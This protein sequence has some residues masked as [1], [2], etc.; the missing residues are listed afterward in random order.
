ML[1]PGYRR[2]GALVNKRNL[3]FVKKQQLA[4]L[5][6]FVSVL[7]GQTMVDVRTQTK[8]IDFSGANS[9]IPAK[10][11]TALPASCKLG[12][13]FFNT[14]NTPGQNL[15]LCAPANTWTMLAGGGSGGGTGS[16]ITVPALTIV[17]N[18]PQYA[19]T[20]GSAL[21]A[22]LSIVT[23]VGTPGSA[24]NIP[25]ESA[26]RSALSA[27]GGTFSNLAGGTN[28]SATLLIGTGASLAP[29]GSG[30]IIATS[31]PAGGVTG[32]APSATTDT[33]NAGNITSGTL[34]AARLPNPSATTLGGVQSATTVSHQWVNSIS[35][36]GVPTLSQPTAADITGLAPS[37]T[38]D[39]TNASNIASGTLSSSL[40]PLVPV[41]K[42]GT[43]TATPALVAGSNVAISGSWP[44]QTISE[45]VLQA[46]QHVAEG[47]SITTGY[48]AGGVSNVTNLAAAYPTLLATAE[49]ATLA[50]HAVAGQQACDMVF[51]QTIKDSNT[52]DNNSSIFTMMIGTN[53]AHVKGVGAYEPVF[54]GCHKAAIAWNAVGNKVAANSANCTDTGTWLPWNYNTPSLTGEYTITPGS[55]KSCSIFTPTGTLYAWVWE[56]DASTGAYT[57]SI[58]GGAPV[59]ATVATSTP[60]ATQNGGVYG[61]NLI[62]FTGLTANAN[63]TILFTVTTASTNNGFAI[64]AIGTPPA[65]GVYGAPRV[66]VGGVPK[67]QGDAQSAATA[68]YNADALADV[69]LLAG[70]GLNVYFVPVRNYLCTSVTSGV[71]YNSYGVAD[72]NTPTVDAG[73]LHPNQV[74]QNDLKQ[75]FA[76]AE[77]FV[78]YVSSTNTSTNGTVNSASAGQFAYYSAAG[79]AVS[80][81]TLVASDIPALSYD[82]SGAAA[83]AQAASLQKSTN[84]SDLTSASTAR[85]NLGLGTA[86]TQAASAFQS[87]LTFTGTGS[88]TVSGTAAGASGNCAKWDANGNVIDAGSPCGTGSGGSSAWSSLTPGTNTSGAFVFGSG[89]SLAASGTGTIAA[90]SVPA[91]GVS[92]TLASSQ[93]P[94]PSASNLGGVQSAAAVAHQW[95]NSI[96]TAGV[97]ALS[98]P[99]FTDVSGTAADSQLPSDQCTLT[100]YPVSYTSLQ[101]AASATPTYTLVTLPS[102][103]TRI[104]LLEISGSA[105]FTGTSITAATVR[106]QSAASTPLLYSPNQDIGTAVNTTPNNDFWSDS[107]NMA[108]RTNLNVVA[109]FTFTGGLSSALTAGNVYITIGTRNM[110]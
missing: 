80:G 65:Q 20:S 51:S 39:T 82:A 83:T 52:L 89:A 27:T 28:T 74:G 47:D 108:D 70:D 107:G 64:A 43:G 61:Y 88:Q 102:T 24:T 29:S 85:T 23:S 57:Y 6:W 63:H 32:L 34:S 72:M 55:T 103:S 10:S 36:S 22:G 87:P 50:D 81:H 84:L 54:Q 90:T 97:P 12:E 33:T 11:G 46:S 94:N 37:A 4:T 44:A 71:C 73:G 58:D 49:G 93:L 109:A 106:L 42:G 60:I 2:T 26:V 5:L 38:T 101:A 35:T 68:Q 67:Q 104:C 21:A 3:S 77:Q 41:T 17:G 19:N 13:M 14:T 40:L 15:Y 30:T 98:Q 25:T 100:K 95:I 18:V 1:R 45:T 76:A 31:V 69:N 56:Q 92:G 48:E 59:A 110:P 9:T 7:S 96:S 99:A 16:G 66:F 8:N 91:S 105:G 53:D 86:A 62:R 79:T 75:A 78:P